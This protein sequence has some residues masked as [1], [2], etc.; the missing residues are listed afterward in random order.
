MCGTNLS[1]VVAAVVVVAAL[2][3]A[4]APPAAVAL[5]LQDKKFLKDLKEDED[6][7]SV[8]V[9]AVQALSE[10]VAAEASLVWIPDT[11]L[12]E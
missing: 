9:A 11:G 1:T 8:S 7:A 4:D 10:A 6:E 12:G 5:P 2:L 3:A